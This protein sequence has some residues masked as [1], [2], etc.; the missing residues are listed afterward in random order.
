MLFW[1]KSSISTECTYIT[2]SVP[3]ITSS[4]NLIVMRMTAIRIAY[5]SNCIA[6]GIDS[7]ADDV[8]YSASTIL[9]E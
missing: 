2:T 9:Q 8:I 1:V 7:N 4:D 3:G 5:D 6:D